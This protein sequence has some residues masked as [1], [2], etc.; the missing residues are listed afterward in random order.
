MIVYTLRRSTGL[1]LKVVEPK[2]TRWNRNGPVLKFVWLISPTKEYFVI[3]VNFLYI[4][5]SFSLVRIRI[6]MGFL[7][8][9]REFN[10][11]TDIYGELIE[12]K[13]LCPWARRYQ[14][15]LESIRAGIF[16]NENLQNFNIIENL[17]CGGGGGDRVPF[18]AGSVRVLFLLGGNFC[19]VPAGF[20]K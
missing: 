11:L 19:R 14:R 8:E 18:T 3:H 15:I 7:V 12:V 4:V 9:L 2:G 13:V 1:G 17:F 6:F 16:D 20:Q 5:V 10:G